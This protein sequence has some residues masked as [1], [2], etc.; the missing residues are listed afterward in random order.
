MDY[1]CFITRHST[2]NLHPTSPNTAK[3]ANT[4]RM[5]KGKL[6]QPPR[7]QPQLHK[8]RIIKDVGLFMSA[9]PG[10]CDL[11][12]YKYTLDLSCHPTQPASPTHLNCDMSGSPTILHLLGRLFCFI[13]IALSEE[14][15]I[16]VYDDECINHAPALIVGY[17]CLVSDDQLS[18]AEAL[19]KL[20]T[21]KLDVNPE[22]RYL[23]EIDL[24]F[25]TA[26]GMATRSTIHWESKKVCSWL[27]NRSGE[28]SEGLR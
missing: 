3:S 14:E 16:L 11:S 25:R 24:Y 21:M 8:T 7:Q 12:E 23:E 18:A 17:M 2:W 1:S 20:R 5:A 26:T 9:Y 13:A 15:N 19:S 22:S 6:S 10:N 4:C 27:D 28:N